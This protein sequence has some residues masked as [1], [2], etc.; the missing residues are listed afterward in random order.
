MK[1]RNENLGR[2]GLRHFFN[3][4]SGGLASGLVVQP[5]QVIKTAFQ[6]K[7]YSHCTGS[8]VIQ[9]PGRPSIMSIIRLIYTQEGLGG[10][11]RGFLP[12]CI[13]SALS[14][15]TYFYLLSVARKAT[16]FVQTKTLADIL[17]ASLARTLQCFV[18]NPIL[19]VKTRFEVVGFNEYKGLVDAFIQIYRK[20][21]LRSFFTNGIEYALL[22]DVPFSAAQFAVYEAIKNGLLSLRTEKQ[23]TNSYVNTMIYSTSS[24]LGTFIGCLITNPLD[25][26]RTRV[27]FQY[28]NKNKQQHYKGVLDAL[29][30]LIKYDGWRGMLFGLQSRFIKKATG[31]IIAWTI[32]ECLLDWQKK[33]TARNIN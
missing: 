30:K 19:I 8:A 32:Y 33:G 31:A 17:A 4:V 13:K 28:Y 20:E 25:V 6:V 11:Y 23:K 14:A 21:G 7:P 29:G 15:G 5:L 24:L 2:L 16:E 3:G 26:I 12:G 10:L 18:T 27:V 1:K 22:K 9:V